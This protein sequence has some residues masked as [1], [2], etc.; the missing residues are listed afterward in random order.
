MERQ[1]QVSSKGEWEFED[2]SRLYKTKSSDDKGQLSDA[3]DRTYPKEDFVSFVV[4][5][6][7]N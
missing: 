1:D 3:K 2:G 4:P 7:Q 5:F 6:L